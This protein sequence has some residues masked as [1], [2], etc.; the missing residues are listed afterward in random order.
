MTTKQTDRDAAYAF[1][2]G[3]WCM[4]FGVVT[5]LVFTGDPL[6]MIVGGVGGLTGLLGAIWV[7]VGVATLI[8]RALKSG[9]T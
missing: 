5:P 6:G 2:L 8:Y 9:D 7:Y 3:A 4:P 1:K